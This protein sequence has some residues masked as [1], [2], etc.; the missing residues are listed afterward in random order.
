VS[1][2]VQAQYEQNPYPR[3]VTAAPVVRP[4]RI[5]EYLR[6]RFPRA[7]FRPL[8]LADGPEVLIAGCGTGLHPIETQRKFPGARLLAVDLSRTSLA[9]AARKAGAL[10]L[11]IEFAQADLLELGPIERRFDVIEASGSLHHLAD[12]AAGWRVMLRLLRP[13]GVMLL[14][15]YSARARADLNV[16]RAYVKEHRYGATVEEIRRFRQ[17]AMAWPEGTPGRS[18]TQHGDFYSTSG[19]RDLLFHVQEYQY[20]LPEIAAFI[21]EEKLTFLGFETDARVAHEYAAANPDDPAMTDLDRWHRFECANPN[22]FI[23]MYQFW[24]QKP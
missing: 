9:Y 15:L 7:P 5:N 3:W 4:L 11:S 24:V 10:G 14:G 21:A 20:D 12:P 6:E 16:A 13:G 1:R 18:V 22:V 8:G 23:G 2:A 19:C 17:E